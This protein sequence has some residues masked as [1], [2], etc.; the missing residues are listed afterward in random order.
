VYLA[1]KSKNSLLLLT[2]VNGKVMISPLDLNTPMV[3]SRPAINSS[4]STWLSSR[5]AFSIATPSS[6]ERE[7]T[8]DIPILEPPL[9]GLTNEVFLHDVLYYMDVKDLCN[10]SFVSRSWYV[11]S[12]DNELWK[13]L[14]K[15]DFPLQPIVNDSRYKSKAPQFSWKERY[16]DFALERKW[17]ALM[18]ATGELIQ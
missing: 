2:S 12:G 4:T 15:R 9:L 11:F 3:N 18:M 8:F 16:R 10:C 17:T 5:K 13:K 6:S 7:L 14:V 1:S